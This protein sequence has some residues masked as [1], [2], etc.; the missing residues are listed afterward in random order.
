MD[1]FDSCKGG[2]TLYSYDRLK[3]F[4]DKYEGRPFY[5]LKS[6]VFRDN[7]LK[8]DRAFKSVYPNFQIAY[9]YKTNY[10]S[11]FCQI[12]N[13]LGGYAEVVSDMELHWA[14]RI[15][16]D[17]KFKCKGCGHVIVLERQEALKKIIKKVNA[18][19]KK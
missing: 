5:L 1:S 18:N 3:C 4:D 15:G 6:N 13:D 7:Y 17:F 16:V 2:G 14:R 12:I 9:S 11:K 8:L 10:T 19:E